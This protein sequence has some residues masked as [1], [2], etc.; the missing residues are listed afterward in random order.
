M[1]IRYYKLGAGCGFIGKKVS[2]KVV[3]FQSP[4]LFKRVTWWHKEQDR[5]RN[6]RRIFGDY[7]LVYGSHNPDP[8]MAPYR[9]HE[10][11]KEVTTYSHWDRKK[12]ESFRPRLGFGVDPDFEFMKEAWN[13]RQFRGLPAASLTRPCFVPGCEPQKVEM[14]P[15][16][17]DTG[18]SAMMSIL[19]DD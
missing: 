16:D 7:Y 18:T 14:K 13:E 4:T 19:A 12:L 9:N 11:M 17:G 15:F 5:F 6:A 2:G 3:E 8:W 10:P 1:M